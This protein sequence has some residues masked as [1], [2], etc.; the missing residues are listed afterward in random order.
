MAEIC[1]SVRVPVPL[2]AQLQVLAN[3]KGISL[4][5][6]LQGELARLVDP[7]AV[8]PQPP[9][10]GASRIRTAVALAAG[11]CP[12]CLRSADMEPGRKICK[13]CRAYLNVNSSQRRKLGTI[14]RRADL[15]DL[16]DGL[17]AM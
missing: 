16:C 9:N 7:D 3:A 1:I 4:H 2:R 14:Q 15:D 11:R 8:D 6:Y 12:R 10:E 13:R 5:R 17:E